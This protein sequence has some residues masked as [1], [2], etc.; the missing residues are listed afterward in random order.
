MGFLID[1]QR[2]LW[3][4]TIVAVLNVR[5]RRIRSRLV[6]ADN[7]LYHTLSTSRTLMR[8]ARESAALPGFLG[9]PARRRTKEQHGETHAGG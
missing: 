2:G 8:R 6:L 3:T 1:R 7:S 4:R 9:A 5:L